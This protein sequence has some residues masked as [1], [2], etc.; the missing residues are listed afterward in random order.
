MV[1]LVHRCL[2]Y[3]NWLHLLSNFAFAPLFLFRNHPHSFLSFF[4][5]SLFSS[6]PR[7]TMSNV[8]HLARNSDGIVR[9]AR[10]I[11][12]RSA[13]KGS[14]LPSMKMYLQDK[15]RC[16]PISQAARDE[17]TAALIATTAAVCATSVVMA[18][19]GPEDDEESAGKRR[20]TLAEK[21]VIA[22]CSRDRL[23]IPVVPGRKKKPINAAAVIRADHIREEKKKK[24]ADGVPDEEEK[25]K[26]T[27]GD[28]R[29]TF[30]RKDVIEEEAEEVDDE[31]AEEE[32]KRA[33]AGSSS[34]DD[35][36]D[37]T[38]ADMTLDDSDADAPPSAS[39]KKRARNI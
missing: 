7:F 24:A 15:L 17:L 8:E 16:G 9:T 27:K 20:Q 26:K 2:F 10:S 35:G 19:N 4:P 37:P 13:A 5:F 38:D 3:S 12:N 21:D 25:K 30:A 22:A 32:E 33:D 36:P 23:N 1:S 34:D 29:K 28:K 31:E 39:A 14:S 6:S 11:M 18:T